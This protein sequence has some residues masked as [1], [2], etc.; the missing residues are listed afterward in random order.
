MSILDWIILI[1]TL[2]GIMIYG[3]YNSKKQTA[4][5]YL[6][7]SKQMPW[8][9]VLLGIMATQASAITFISGPGQSYA[10]GMRFLQYYFGLP[11]AMVVVAAVFVPLFQKAN[12]YTAYASG[13]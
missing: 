8:Y 9:V 13:K 7:A 5:D 4:D 3:L 2:S 1:T 10:D 6:R 11:I 12:A